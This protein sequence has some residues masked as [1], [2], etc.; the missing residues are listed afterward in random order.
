M[1]NEL[2]ESQINFYQENGFLVIENFLDAEELAEWQRCTDESVEERLGDSVEFMTN[3]MD[4]KQ[5]YARVFTQCLRLSDT[6]TGMRKLV[7]DPRLGKMAAQLADVDGVRIWHDQALIKPPHGNPTAWHL[8]VP[9]WSFDS[10]MPSRSGLR[11]TMPRLRTDA[12]GISP[13]PI[14]QPALITS[15]LE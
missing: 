12:C 5:F 13:A 2:T 3:Q 1:Q 15:A 11:W 7:H 4:A 8:D 14:K 6:H 9:Y 10:R